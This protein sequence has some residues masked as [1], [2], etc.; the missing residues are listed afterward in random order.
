MAD[1]H[2]QALTAR[3]QPGDNKHNNLFRSILAF[4]DAKEDFPRQQVSRTRPNN[5]RRPN[6]GQLRMGSYPKT[7]G[8]IFSKA[9]MFSIQTMIWPKRHIFASPTLSAANQTK[10]NFFPTR[11]IDPSAYCAVRPTTCTSIHLPV[12]LSSLAPRDPA[13]LM[14]GRGLTAVHGPLGGPMNLPVCLSGPYEPAW[15]ANA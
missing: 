7:S 3:V 5:G 9:L 15:E 8:S 13:G 12:C 4:F 14:T 10:E 1:F 2:W 11:N 6:A